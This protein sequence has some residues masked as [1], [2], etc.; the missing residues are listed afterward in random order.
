MKP[1]VSAS[2]FT[3]LRAFLPALAPAGPSA[4]ARDH[5][6]ELRLNPVLGRGDRSRSACEPGSP[7]EFLD[8]GRVFG[9]AA[10]RLRISSRLRV[11]YPCRLRMA[12]RAGGVDGTL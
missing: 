4:A 9:N 5:A 12:R 7:V 6:L 10:M 2:L 1:L 11:Y 3:H 8:S